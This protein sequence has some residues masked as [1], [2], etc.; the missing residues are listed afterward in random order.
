WLAARV[1]EDDRLA[2]A[3]LDLVGAK[4]RLPHPHGD[5]GLV[6]RVR[7]GR[8]RRQHPGRRHEPGQDEASTPARPQPPG[9]AWSRLPPSGGA[10]HAAGHATPVSTLPDSARCTR[11]G[12]AGSRQIRVP[13]AREI[14]FRTAGAVAIMAGSPTPLAPNGPAGSPDSTRIGMISGTSSAV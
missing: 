3:D 10:G 5:G 11:S 13:V 8:H 2:L 7:H 9:R 14:A 1:L 6:L 4:A 12:V